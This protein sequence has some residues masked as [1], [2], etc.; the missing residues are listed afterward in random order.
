MKLF[1]KIILLILIFFP[2]FCFAKNVDNLFL[3]QGLYFEKFRDIPFTGKITGRIHGKILNGLRDG[4]WEVYYKQNFFKGIFNN[5]TLKVE[6]NFI[7]GSRVGNW[8]YFLN[9]GNLLAKGDYLKN[10]MVGKWHILNSKGHTRLIKDFD[11]DIILKT[12]YVKEFWSNGII[13]SEGNALKDNFNNIESF[14][15]YVKEGF[16]NLEDENYLRFS[17]IRWD[18]K[19]K[20]YDEDGILK[21]IK[22]WENDRLIRTEKVY[23]FDDLVER[24]G[25]YYVKSKNKVFNGEVFGLTNVKFSNGKMNGIL[26]YYYNNGQLFKK[27]P[28]LNGFRE[29]EYLQYSENGIIKIKGF[30]KEDI[31]SGE[32]NYYGHFGSLKSKSYF[33]NGK[34][35]KK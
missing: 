23:S 33:E 19:W 26:K 20:Q 16:D 8:K 34:K 31:P 28:Y 13:K 15:G 4:K 30:Y 14:F 29:G 3:R 1:K 22:Y 9:N 27:I 2:S 6:G 18:G 25:T 10:S 5:Q 35:I 21:A 11:D 32:W 24:D 12:Y 7:K 17:K